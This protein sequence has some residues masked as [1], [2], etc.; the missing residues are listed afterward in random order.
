MKTFRT[1][2]LIAGI[3]VAGIAVNT[4]LGQS[5]EKPDKIEKIEKKEYKRDLKLQTQTE[6]KA[7]VTRPQIKEH[8]KHQIK[9]EIKEQKS[10]D[11]VKREHKV[12]ARRQANF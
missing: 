10:S 5:V 11:K 2:V 9:S 4:A 3:L 6:P 1:I 12:K 7:K 8:R